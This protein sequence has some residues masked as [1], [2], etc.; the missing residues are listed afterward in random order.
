MR[1]LTPC[2]STGMAILISN[3]VLGSMLQA[4]VAAAVDGIAPERVII[5]SIS[6]GSIVVAF[7]IEEAPATAAG[8]LSS[9]DAA[10]QL[11]EMDASTLQSNFAGFVGLVQAPLQVAA[12]SASPSTTSTTSDP[13]DGSNGFVWVLV[14]VALL[15]CCAVVAGVKYKTASG[16]NAE[17]AAKGAARCTAL[18]CSDTRA[19]DSSFFPHTISRCLFYARPY[20]ST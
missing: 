15:I 10:T 20:N 16:S 12:A 2:N 17:N 5:E 7:Y 13:E 1:R 11:T 9:N 19:A 6:G 8:A 4:N 14:V 3:A 18:Y